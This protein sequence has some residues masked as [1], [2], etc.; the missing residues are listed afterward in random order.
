M[1]VYLNHQMTD[2]IS[3]RF[4]INNLFDEQYWNWSEVRG[5]STTDPLLPGLAASGRYFSAGVQ[6]DW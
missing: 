3:V 5:L 6:W 4:A 2:A 1:D